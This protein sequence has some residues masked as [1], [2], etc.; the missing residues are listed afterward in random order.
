MYQVPLWFTVSRRDS[1]WRWL[2]FICHFLLWKSSH[3]VIRPPTTT[4]VYRNVYRNNNIGHWL[5]NA[6]VIVPLLENHSAI[7]LHLA[8]ADIAGNRTWSPDLW[9]GSCDQLGSIPARARRHSDG[10]VSV[11]NFYCQQV[12]FFTR[13]TCRVNPWCSH[14]LRVICAGRLL[15]A[16]QESI[17]DTGFG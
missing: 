14:V 10:Q 12:P 6:I 5:Y 13:R 2:S 3:V 7:L 9:V 15:T 11:G 17:H 1:R 16:S 8:P 4:S